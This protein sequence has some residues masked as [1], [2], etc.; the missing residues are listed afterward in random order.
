MIHFCYAD[1]RTKLKFLKFVN[2]QH[3]NMKFTCETENPKRL[4]CY[5]VSLGGEH[6][7]QQ[8]NIYVQKTNI[9]RFQQHLSH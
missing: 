2:V 5:D 3:P 8:H 9:L 7:A 6:L 1:L 4:P